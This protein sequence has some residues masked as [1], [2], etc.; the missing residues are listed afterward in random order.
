MLDLRG[1]CPTVQI[2]PAVFSFTLWLVDHQYRI[3]RCALVSDS[4][5]NGLKWCD[6]FACKGHSGKYAL[7][8][9]AFVNGGAFGAA[10]MLVG[11][12]V[13]IQS[14]RSQNGGVQVVDV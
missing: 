14:H 7:N 2:L 10:L 12:F 5:L 13:M 4:R 11:Q 6:P 1:T 3:S 8:H 9:I